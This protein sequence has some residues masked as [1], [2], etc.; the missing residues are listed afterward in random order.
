MPIEAR[1]ERWAIIHDASSLIILSVSASAAE[2][3]LMC[4]CSSP[5]LFMRSSSS[6]SSWMDLEI[7]DE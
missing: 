3:R 2:I 6:I 5:E 1:A 7:K 4:A